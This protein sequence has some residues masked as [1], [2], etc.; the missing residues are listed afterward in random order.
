MLI[1]TIDQAYEE[2]KARDPGTAI[3]KNLVRQMV[4]TGV[5]PSIKA[6]NKKLVDV[7]VL[8]EYVALVTSGHVFEPV[9]PPA[10]SAERRV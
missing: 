8:E 7:D 5:V 6:G 10:S 4:R 1:R 2:I 3:S 9:E